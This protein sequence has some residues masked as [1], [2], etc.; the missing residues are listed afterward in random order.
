[1][2]AVLIGILL[3]VVAGCNSNPAPY[4]LIP[5]DDDGIK[6]SIILNQM[7][8]RYSPEYWQRLNHLVKF[9]AQIDRQSRR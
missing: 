1:M 9:W 3:A 5:G 7:M 8:S 6:Q 2:R 4:R